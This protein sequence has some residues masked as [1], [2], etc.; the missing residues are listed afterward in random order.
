MDMRAE[1]VD[2]SKRDGGSE[3]RYTAFC[4]FHSTGFMKYAFKFIQNCLFEKDFL[5]FEVEE[6]IMK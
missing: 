3:V 4:H 1:I 2:N 6:K 5:L